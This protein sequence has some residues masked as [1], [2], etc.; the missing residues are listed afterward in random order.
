MTFNYRADVIISTSNN[1][2]GDGICMTEGIIYVL[3]NEAMPGYIKIGKTS[4]CV[5]KRIKELDN[6]SLPFPFECFYAARVNDMDRAERLLH[7][8]FD[9]TRITKRREFFSI[10]PER[11]RSAIKL[12]EIED[13]TPSL[14]EVIE[15][16]DDK[17]AIAKAKRKRIQ[18]FSELG[19]D[20]GEILTFKKDPNITC[21]VAENKRVLFRNQETSLSASALTILNEMGYEWS[22]VNGWQFWQ[23]QDRPLYEIWKDSFSN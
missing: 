1:L 16:T 14:D 19:I 13:V 9:D 22:T 6:T 15:N 12:A 3:I 18:S 20:R 7:D 5:T 4:Y 17:S 11:V 23:Y 10:E 2:K 8:A 21:I